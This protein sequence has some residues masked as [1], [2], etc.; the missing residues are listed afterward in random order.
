MINTKIKKKIVMFSTLV[1]CI[2]SN[3]ERQ[4]W[5][6]KYAIENFFVYIKYVKMLFNNLFV[7]MCVGN[8]FHFLLRRMLKRLLLYTNLRVGI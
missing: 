2:L 7:Y 1:T 5:H 6:L 4:A 3:A 8:Y